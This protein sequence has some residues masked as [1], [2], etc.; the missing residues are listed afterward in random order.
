MYR[1]PFSLNIETI[2][3]QFMTMASLV[4]QALRNAAFAFRMQD[5]AL[6]KVVKKSDAQ[7][8]D[9]QLLIEDAVAET[10]ATQQPVA[11]DLRLLISLLKIVGD[12]ERAGDYAAH[13]AKA[14]K[15][16]AD[17]P[18]W[19]QAE[20]LERMAQLGQTMVN[21]TAEAFRQ[22]DA[23]LARETAGIDDEI[24]KEHKTV[25]NEILKLV[26][27]VPDQ[28]ERASKILTVSGYLERL[29]DHMTNA[30]EAVVF[31]VE[32]IHVDLNE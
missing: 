10:I 18:L 20:R 21:G 7:I 26:Q 11:R 4:Q 24:D 28:M 12:F 25:I 16:F 19:R 17:A 14:T 23:V 1:E 6:A 30:C 27:T 29:G 32:G 9:L 31:M 5:T 22:R 8:D 15:F 13:L 2:D 3:T